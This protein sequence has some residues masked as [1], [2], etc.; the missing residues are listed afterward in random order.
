MLLELLIMVPV[1][2]S[3][4]IPGE[5]IPFSVGSLAVLAAFNYHSPDTVELRITSIPPSINSV[6]SPRMSAAPS[7]HPS[8]LPMANLPIS[9]PPSLYETTYQQYISNH[10]FTTK[11]PSG[12]NLQVDNW[13]GRP[14]SADS[15]FSIGSATAKSIKGA[16]IQV[17]SKGARAPIT[18]LPQGL[19]LPKS[20]KNDSSNVNPFPMGPGKP[21]QI[22][23]NQAEYAEQFERSSKISIPRPIFIDTNSPAL[24]SWPSPDFIPASSLR[25]PG[26]VLYGSD[27]IQVRRQNSVT[28]ATRRTSVNV[29]RQSYVT[30]STR[31]SLISSPVWSS[32]AR[33]SR[34][35]SWV[36][37]NEEM[38]VLYE[39]SSEG[40]SGIDDTNPVLRPRTF[41]EQSFQDAPIFALQSRGSMRLSSH[42]RAEHLGPRI[43]GPRPPPP[44]PL[45]AERGHLTR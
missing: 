21:Q 44:I 12:R 41:G 22:L 25:S 26:S 31:D 15:C 17:A 32:P 27:I 6:F 40:T 29:W 28:S 9:G 45:R 10:P 34:R 18:R 24:R 5:F 14:M 38:P 13:Q 1:A 37:P 33:S 23:P 8:V 2:M 19:Q 35:H 43:R 30:S 39:A 20:T 42:S 7:V 11:S 16:A 36:A 4:G 3:T